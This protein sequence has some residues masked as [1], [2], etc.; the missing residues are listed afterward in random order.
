MTK[1]VF[2]TPM[3]SIPIDA[4]TTFGINA[5]PR[6][7]GHPIG[8]FGTGLKYAVAIILRHGGRIQLFVDGTEYEFYTYAKDFRG[9]EFQSVRMKKR[10][11]VLSK[12]RSQELPFT[13]ELGKNWELWQAFR[14]LESNTRDE[15]GESYALAPQD[16]DGT[17]FWTNEPGTVIV[18]DCPGFAASA[19]A[20]EVFF[21]PDNERV[22]RVHDA[23]SFSMYDR[24]SRHLYYRGI[25][26]YT[27]RHPARFTYDIKEGYLELSEDRTAKNIW[28]VQWDIQRAIVNMDDEDLIRRMFEKGDGTKTYE[29]ED[30]S[31]EDGGGW[32]FRSVAK[33]LH[34]TGNA[35]RSISRY[36][37]SLPDDSAWGDESTEIRLKDE[38]WEL[39]VSRLRGED[40][41]EDRCEKLAQYIQDRF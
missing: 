26:V 24:P 28:L 13:T 36:W 23:M 34:E 41:D 38:D 31:F 11:G 14:E 32:A 7:G 12:W 22:E 8:Y 17:D 29:G 21:D 10:N 33:N 1:Y 5:K 4:F 35:M 25:R 39:I 2:T 30:L 15:Q 9:K 6:A 20:D 18:V 16:D 19:D 3:S 27:F 37:T 40:C